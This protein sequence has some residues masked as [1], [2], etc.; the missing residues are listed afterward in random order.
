MTFERAEGGK[1]C[2]PRI[3]SNPGKLSFRNEGE[4]KT[5][6]G[7]LKQKEFVDSRPAL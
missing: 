7:R 1:N 4:M 5:L 3:L 2:Q 6:P